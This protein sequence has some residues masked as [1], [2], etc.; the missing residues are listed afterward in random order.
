MK[1]RIIK[2][3]KGG[4]RKKFKGVKVNPL[5]YI[6]NT[7]RD[8]KKKEDKDNFQMNNNFNE[9]NEYGENLII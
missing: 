2:S 9:L 6:I 1:W 7:Y 3:F 8:V 4:K 5:N